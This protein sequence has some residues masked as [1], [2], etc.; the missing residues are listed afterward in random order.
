MN[1]VAARRV[2]PTVMLSL[3]LLGCH[4]GPRSTGAAAPR[5]AAPAAPAGPSAAPARV[6]PAA[7]DDES[8]DPLDTF[9]QDVRRVKSL[10]PTSD[11]DGVGLVARWKNVETGRRLSLIYVDTTP[12]VWKDNMQGWLIL[13]AARGN[14]S[15]MGHIAVL[16]PQLRAG[17]FHGSEHSH[18]TVIGSLMAPEWTPSAPEAGWTLNDG[19][20]CDIELHPVGDRGDLEGRFRG[21]LPANEGSTYYLLEDGYL[22]IKGL[23]PEARE[24]CNGAAGC[25]EAAE[26]RQQSGDVVGAAA[27]YGLACS[28]RE[29]AACLQ[30]GQLYEGGIGVTRDLDRALGYFRKA[31]DLGERRGGPRTIRALE[32]LC[33]DG[34]S[35]ACAVVGKL[36][37]EGEYC[38]ADLPGRSMDGGRYLCQACSGGRAE[39][40]QLTAQMHLRCAGDSR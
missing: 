23:P 35:H 32:Q 19:G 20:W 11:W 10:L 36:L 31:C 7:P 4:A 21:K 39:A 40:C 30:A 29:G 26:Q 27:A 17:R 3:G 34:E 2:L 5:T 16:L 28:Q 8:G 1:G 18:R 12:P 37:Y 6:N 24:G 14:R 22:Y 9:A 33:R 38:G 25:L 13:S 15:V